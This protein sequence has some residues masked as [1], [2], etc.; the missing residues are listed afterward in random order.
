MEGRAC[1]PG[2][3]TI[4]GRQLEWP[5][6]SRKSAGL[7]LGVSGGALAGAAHVFLGFLKGERGR[8]DMVSSSVTE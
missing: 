3:W 7:F 1:L 6:S 4:L 2:D 8:E 5:R